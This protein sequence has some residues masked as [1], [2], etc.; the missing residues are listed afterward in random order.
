MIDRRK[1]RT[2]LERSCAVCSPRIRTLNGLQSCAARRNRLDVWDPHRGVPSGTV[3][4]AAP[5]LPYSCSSSNINSTCKAVVA[6]SSS[7]VAFANAIE[8][9][10]AALAPAVVLAIWGGTPIKA[11]KKSIKKQLFVD[12]SK[13]YKVYL[14]NISSIQR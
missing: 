2:T 1:W 7:S 5:W 13:C 11:Q 6:G 14:S 12:F 9:V 3:D 8:I 10:A 4:P